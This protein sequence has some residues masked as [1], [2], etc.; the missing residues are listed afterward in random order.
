MSSRYYSLRFALSLIVVLSVFAEFA[1]ADVSIESVEVGI[2]QVTRPG[3]WTRLRVRLQSTEAVSC[4]VEATTTD[5]IGNLATFPSESVEVKAN[6]PETV[7]F[8]YQT[9]RLEETVTLKVVSQDGNVIASRR[10]T[11]AESGSDE[12]D[13]SVVK[14]TVPVWVVAG[15]I[16]SNRSGKSD[17]QSVQ[18]A[19]T[20]RGVKI[21][22]LE[23]P[24]KLPASSEAY[25]A[26]NTVILT[27]DFNLTADQSGA[28]DH[29]VQSGGHV[30][31]VA[32]TRTEKLAKCPLNYW[33]LKGRKVTASSLSDLSGL[34]AFAKSS[35]R[36]PIATRINGSTI[37]VKDGAEV[38]TGIEG[39][40]L[41]RSA[42]GF[43]RV[44]ILGVD[45][46]RAP[47]SRWRSLDSFVA[48]VADL[49]PVSLDDES[50]GQRISHSG[51]TELATQFQIGMETVPQ[52]GD[53]STL[54][55]LGLVLLFL[56]V[57][58]P[59]DY[60]LV[61]RFLKKP[62]LT[63]LTF[64][65]IVVGAG[66]LASSVAGGANGRE[67]RSR[68]CEVIDLDA[69]T[70]FVR[71]SV[72]S[73][74][75]SPEHRRY[76]VEIGHSVDEVTSP[77]AKDGS[78]QYE[79][80]RP[81]W[82]SAPEV[83]FGGMYRAPGLNLSGTVYQFSDDRFEIENLPIAAASDRI[84]GSTS[85]L[86]VSQD[87]F[88]LNLKQAGT[89]HLSR[90]STFTH[91]LHCPID[92]WVL[93]YGNRVYFHDF[94]AGDLL[95]S[96]SIEPGV[97]WSSVG[98]TTGGRELRSFLT[99]SRFQRTG[100]KSMSGGGD[101]FTHTQVDWNRRETDLQTI[102]RMLTFYE[103]AG[104]RDYTGLLNS[105]YASLE[106]SK[107]LPLDRAILFGKID[108][109]GSAIDVDGEL[110]QTDQH[111]TYIRV[112]LKVDDAPIEAQLPKFDK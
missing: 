107:S 98:K 94:Q 19:L 20:D 16:G 70:G 92:D 52:V 9:G 42:H 1:R 87:L 24:G 62:G 89:G 37:Q 80:G 53:R 18:K 63:W 5:P 65:A 28:L 34:E 84:L 73:T 81:H 67:I 106:M 11:G 71:H 82:V 66:V 112:L 44:T 61:H 101:E 47:L 2:G 27:G 14:H 43:G 96:S 108:V 109:P 110:L 21:A 36:I 7:S 85:T 77:A 3:I 68:M 99:G 23:S 48:A 58:G 32:G 29:W 97:A 102:L 4:R 17:Q 31:V 100:K 78:R 75:Y 26:V 57:I 41:T 13:F 45:L 55:V 95:G 38:V 83:N 74:I 64:P 30:V 105:A 60:L 8:V 49:P 54:S 39:P 72:W 88:D 15:T 76:R 56:L 86:G 40:L 91:H 79:S 104:G 35:F 69:D 6:Q 90:E 50:S 111:E 93:V 12:V 33:V 10:L 59:L 25:S 103:I 46:D 22:S 51:I